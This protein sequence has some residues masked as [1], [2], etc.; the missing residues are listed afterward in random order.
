VESLGEE[1]SKARYA[2]TLLTQGKSF[3]FRGVL[4]CLS[5]RCLILVLTFAV[6]ALCRIDSFH[7]FQ[8]RPPP[9]LARRPARPRKTELKLVRVF[10]AID[11]VLVLP[12]PML[13]REVAV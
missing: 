2:P 12:F 4:I 9:E 7:R 10:V 3:F 6:P 13:Q 8:C 5:R 11:A 1:A